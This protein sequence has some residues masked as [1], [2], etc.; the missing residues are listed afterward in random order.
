MSNSVTMNY[1]VPDLEGKLQS[2][3]TLRSLPAEDILEVTLKVFFD[4]C[5]LLFTQHPFGQSF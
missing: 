3:R 5:R 4:D 2:F 1:D